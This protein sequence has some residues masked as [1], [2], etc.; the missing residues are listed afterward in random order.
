[1]PKV[2]LVDTNFSSGPILH[3]LLERGHEV[4]VVGGNPQDSLAKAAEHYWPLDYSVPAEL[5]ALVAREEFTFLVPGCNDQ[6]YRACVQVGEGRFPGFD[7]SDATRTLNDKGAFKLMAERLGLPVPRRK[8]ESEFLGGGKI[9]VKPVDSFSGKGITVVDSGDMAALLEAKRTAIRASRS[10]Q[11]LVEAFVEGQL[12]SHSAFISGGSV[13]EDFVVQEN[14]TANP[15]A[16][17]TSR[18]ALDFPNT[19]LSTLRA[20]V[21]AIAIDLELV[22]GLF[23]T[24]FIRQDED[25][26]I[27][28]TTRRCPGDLYSQL[29]ELS[30]GADFTKQYVR[31][32]LGEPLV[33]ATSGLSRFVM[34]HTITVPAPQ[35][36]ASINFLR[37]LNLER[38]VP[39]SLVGDQL[40]ASPYSRLA[41]IFCTADSRAEL[42]DIYQD[43]I[44]RTLYNVSDQYR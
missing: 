35:R 25:L 39:L 44:A 20:H 16:V 24:Q 4:H 28:E 40:R 18:I 21:A 6:S 17:D 37:S 2:L 7:G 43:A 31:P 22:D 33:R 32:F 8:P 42:D 10:G 1:M 12:F 19:A 9:I 34:R 41:L 11:F 5:S 36:F 29:I 30:T 23:H 3:E 14:C 26:W 15:F 27:V 38:L 13:V